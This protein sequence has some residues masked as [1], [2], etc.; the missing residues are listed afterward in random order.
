MNFQNK[1]KKKLLNGN[2]LRVFVYWIGGDV[3]IS[4]KFMDDEFNEQ[5]IVFNTL[6][7]MPY[8]A[9]YSGDIKEAPE[10][11]FE[12]ID[13]TINPDEKRRYLLVEISSFF[14]LPLN[15][16]KVIQVGYLTRKYPK[17]DDIL[18]IMESEDMYRIDTSSKKENIYLFDLLNRHSFRLAE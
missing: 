16:N 4:A 12:Y 14:E 5:T 6:K 15:N 3:D 2:T 13:I 17:S 10:G 7:S 11:A 18:D 8:Q 9:C 1:P